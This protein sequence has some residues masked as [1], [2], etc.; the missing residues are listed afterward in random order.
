V[1]D[2]KAT[3]EARLQAAEAARLL[4]DGAVIDSGVAFILKEEMKFKK[5]DVRELH[6]EV[7][8]VLLPSRTALSELR[9]LQRK[10]GA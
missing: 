6:Q 1:K 7:L 2:S 3:P 4:I 9:E 8:N 5:G 10:L